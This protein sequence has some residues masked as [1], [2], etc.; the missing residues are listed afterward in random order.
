[1][2]YTFTKEEQAWR[3]EV[4]DFLQQEEPLAK[5]HC[6]GEDDFYGYGAWSHSFMQ[7]LAEKR[8]IGRTWPRE[9]GGQ[10]RPLIELFILLDELAYFKAPAAA[11]WTN[12]AFC[13]PIAT[14]GSEELK[15][16]FLPR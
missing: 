15:R 11:L 1:M 7:R 14:Y 2:D 13:I 3:K 4:H 12:E 6:E 10:G 16:S 9:Y 8:W 5:Y